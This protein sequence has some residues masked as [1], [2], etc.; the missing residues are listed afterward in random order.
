[1]IEVEVEIWSSV[2]KC[3]DYGDEMNIRDDGFMIDRLIPLV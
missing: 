1:M 3:L 2:L